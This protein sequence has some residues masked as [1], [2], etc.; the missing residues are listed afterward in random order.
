MADI[1]QVTG[2][3]KARYD[4]EKK[5]LLKLIMDNG[6]QY[7]D[8]DGSNVPDTIQRGASIRIPFKVNGQYLNIAGK[9]ELLAAGEAPAAAAPGRPSGADY[10]LGLMK[11]SAM[12]HAVELTRQS[13]GSTS[14]GYAIAV[15]QSF[16]EWYQGKDTADADSISEE[17]PF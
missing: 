4:N 5:P 2:T 15:A 12:A 10:D 7:T 11:R 6:E 9:C 1:Q 14:P 16:L 17:V 8:Y 13:D 3:V